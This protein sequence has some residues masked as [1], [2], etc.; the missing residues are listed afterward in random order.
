MKVTQILTLTVI[1]AGLACFASCKK[2]QPAP[3][4]AYDTTPGYVA[5]SK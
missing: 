1:A 5:P 4:P 2:S 3:P